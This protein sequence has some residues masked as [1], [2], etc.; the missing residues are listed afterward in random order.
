MPKALIVG[1]GIGGLTA[2]LCFDLIGWDVQLLERSDDIREVGAGIQI[3]PNAMKVF[4]RLGLDQAL[5]NAGF[6]PDAIELRMG[7]SGMDLIRAPL[8]TIAMRRWGAP[9]LHIHRADLISI[10]KTALNDRAPNAL[11]L[12]HRVVGYNTSSDTVFAEL[13][14]GAHFP[15]DLLVGADGIHSTI[16]EQMVG[17]DSPRFTG[18]VA[19]RAVVPVERLGDDAPRGVAGAWMGKGKHAVTYLLKDGRVANFVGV[20]ERDDWTQESWT[21]EGSKTEALKDFS[22]WHP[23]ITRLIK[24]ADRLYR[25]ALFDRAPLPG[26]IDG[27]A[28]LLG[29]AAHPMLPFMAQGSAMAIED[30]WALAAFM[31]SEPSRAEALWAYQALRYPRTSAM[32]KGSRANAKTFHKRTRAGQLSTYGPMWLAGRLFPALGLKRQDPIYGYDITEK[33]PNMP[34]RE[35]AKPSSAKSAAPP[36]LPS[37]DR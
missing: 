5:A 35:D 27:H 37:Q 8:G 24:E 32:Q 3:S 21:E 25:W 33:T 7:I 12:G 31:A 14:D 2:A 4:K 17:P 1:S 20:V 23:T 34:V 22:D 36:E 13:A 19:W 10:L 28:V 18:N 11:Q 26:W 16:R 9:Y 6:A 29:D 15:G 30:A